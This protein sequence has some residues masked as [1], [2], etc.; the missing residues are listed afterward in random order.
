VA[1]K[2]FSLQFEAAVRKSIRYSIFYE[3][4]ILNKHSKFEPDTTWTSDV[5]C[6]VL[7]FNRHPWWWYRSVPKHVRFISALLLEAI[8]VR[9]HVL[10]CCF[11]ILLKMSAW[12]SARMGTSDHRLSHPYKSPVAVTSGLTSIINALVKCLFIQIVELAVVF[13]CNH[14]WKTEGLR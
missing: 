9:V 4:P 10:F 12:M 14:R 3:V 11:A 13:M 2:S 1:G 6:C 8:K 5:W 7:Y